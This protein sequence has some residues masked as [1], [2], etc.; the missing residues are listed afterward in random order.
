MTRE[1]VHDDA[2]FAALAV[3]AFF[4]RNAAVMT[5][6]GTIMIVGFFSV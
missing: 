4:I 2:A 3:G 1:T 5:V 6:L